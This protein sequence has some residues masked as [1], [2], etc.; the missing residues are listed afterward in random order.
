MLKK[1]NALFLALELILCFIYFTPAAAITTASNSN[2]NNYS[3]INNQ[4]TTT[5]E[6][7]LI[8]HILLPYISN[9]LMEKNIKPSQFDLNDITVFSINKISDEA[10]EVK[11]YI[12]ILSEFPGAPFQFYII[13]FT[14]DRES[15]SVTDILER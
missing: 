9:A 7:D 1:L 12:R 11:V 6:K 3:N 8:L 15:I 10:Y 2:V 14:I 5:V 13:T 4:P